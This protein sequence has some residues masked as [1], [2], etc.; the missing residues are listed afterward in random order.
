MIAHVD[1]DILVL[2]GFDYDAGG[3]ALSAFNAALGYPVTIAWRPNTGEATPFDLDGDGRRRGA[4]DAQ[5]YGEFAGQ[6]GMAILSRFTFDSVRSVDYSAMLW[7]DL[8][9]HIMPDMAP[10]IAAAQR[11]STT[12]HWRITFDIAGSPL[13]VMTFHATPPV[14]D[15]PEDRNGRRNHD[16]V[17]F[18]H[19]LLDGTLGE[20]PQGPLVI[21]G[22]ANLDPADGD[23][24][25]EAMRALLSHPRLQDPAPRSEGGTHAAER[26]GGMNV[27]QRGDPALDTADW[28]DAAPWPGNLRVDY[29]L[30]SRDLTIIDSGVFWPGPE[31]PQVV[32][33]GE[34][35]VSRHRLVWV[36]LM[37]GR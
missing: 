34:G 14:F 1:P 32:L 8:P 24:R 35:D 19:Y 26:D 15:G 30:P 12:G 27:A 17:M 37:L 2:Q 3:A 31:D 7:R 11:L 29:V 6:G 20:A 9:G 36:D 28:P 25:S 4:R 5:G 10:E 18:W 23:G 13:T 33:L 21:L 22:D 16:E